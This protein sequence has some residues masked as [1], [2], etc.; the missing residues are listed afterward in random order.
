MPVWVNVVNLTTSS[1]FPADGHD[2]IITAIVNHI[3]GE[4]YGGLSI[5]QPVVFFRIPEVINAIPGIMD[6]D[7]EISADGVTFGA[8]N[9][10]VGPWEKATTNAGQVTIS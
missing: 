10:P 9:I 4:S 5:G 2:Q 1:S 7:L 3:G 8:A 6:Y